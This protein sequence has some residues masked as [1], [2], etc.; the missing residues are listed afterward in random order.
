MVLE[1]HWIKA[2]CSTA[3][4]ITIENSRLSEHTLSLEIE[5]K[6]YIQEG[7]SDSEIV[8]AM[9]IEYGKLALRTETVLDAYFYITDFPCGSSLRLR[10]VSGK[11]EPEL[12]IGHL[13]GSGMEQA[14]TEYKGAAD[15]SRMLGLKTIANLDELIGEMCTRY[16]LEFLVHQDRTKI[17]LGAIEVSL[18]TVRYHRAKSKNIPPLRNALG[19]IYHVSRICEVERKSREAIEF[20]KNIM[21]T[22]NEL[23]LVG[24]VVPETK[25]QIGRSARSSFP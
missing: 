23:G 13:S 25:E 3:S 7:V 8:R 21:Q 10:E 12:K 9:E 2:K 19:E 20:A 14:R 24:E 16:D 4:I 5:F 17:E 1:L 6:R 18:D 11:V 15:V 22:L